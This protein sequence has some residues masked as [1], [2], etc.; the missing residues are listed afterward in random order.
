MLLRRFA[1]IVGI[2]LF[3]GGAVVAAAPAKPQAPPKKKP[4]QKALPTKP[5]DTTPNPAAGSPATPTPSDPGNP[6]AA[7][8]ATPPPAPPPEPPPDMQGTSE[9]PED[10]KFGGTEAPPVV[11]AHPTKPTG[12][13]TE[14]AL[15][16]ITLPANMFEVSIAPHFQASPFAASDALRAR[17]GIT[18]RVQIGLTYL[19]A[20]I[21]D[22]RSVDS[23]AS[24]KYE[25]H[26]GKAFG[27]DATV[28]IQDWIAVKIGVP[29]YV[30]PLAVSL[31]LGVPLKFSFAGK[32]AIG[33]L[34]DLLDIKLH[35]FAPSLYHEVANAQAALGVDN[36]TQQSRGHWRVS[37]FGIYQHSPR[38]AFIA[39]IGV[40]NDLGLSS[41]GPAGTSSGGGTVTFARAGLQYAVRRYFDI[42]ASAGWDSL[43][44][45]GS[46]GPQLFLALRI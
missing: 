12:Y 29:I 34:D 30:N 42:G 40:D 8:S 31:A 11:V 43:A 27:L 16:P 32:Y 46:F 10:P 2:V 13:P 3:A 38:L 18:P 35:R 14:E 26:G 45:L 9:T 22:R 4:A 25:L 44:R 19:Y 24:S 39:R 7:G 17:Y 28:R 15:R 20:G 6:G 36:R 41:D 23:G 5:A 1:S 37:A 33:G 21:Y